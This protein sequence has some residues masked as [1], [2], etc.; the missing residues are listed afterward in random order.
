MVLVKKFIHQRGARM[1]SKNLLPFKFETTKHSTGITGL[2]GLPVYYELARVAGLSKSIEKHLSRLNT[3]QG[4]EVNRIVE[5]LLL[6]NLAGGD[7]VEDIGKLEGDEGLR[8]LFK[9]TEFYGRSRK[10]RHKAMRRFRKNKERAFPSQSTIFRFL[11]KFHDSDQEQLREL[12]KAFIPKLTEGLKKLALINRDQL[13]YLQD[14]QPE[15]IATLD[16][17]ATLV[18]TCKKDALHCYKHFKAYQPLNTYWYEQRVIVHTE[19]RDGNVPAGYNQLRVFREALEHLP[20]GVEK[21]YLRSDTAGYQHDLLKYCDSNSDKKYGKILFAIGCDVTASF[22]Q[23][24][25]EVP[26]KDWHPIYKDVNGKRFESGQ[27]WAEVCFVPNKICSSKK[28]MN[29]RYI[30]MREVM[31]QPELPGMESQQEFPFP[32][33]TINRKR[34]KVFGLVTNIHNW[35]GEEVIKW[36]RQRC[37]KS[38]HVH[39]VM[40]KD[41]AGGQLPCNE[42]GANAAWWW[43]MMISLNLN[44]IMKTLTLEPSWRSKRMKAIRYWLINVP[45]RLIKRSRQLYLRLSPDHPGSDLITQM[46]NRIIQLESVAPG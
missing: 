9:Q 3:S 35:D 37:G 19:F 38:E 1:I 15:K 7:C 4:W 25:L 41:L 6:L 34:Y 23:S 27:E 5:S 39:S 16:M 26:N 21:V 46:R 42:F 14:H 2:S 43:I 13:Q 22:K 33:Q 20:S 11:N 17:D 12:G 29:Y 18:E 45:G 40:K 44:E 24:V 31:G 10:E 30:A 36:Q 32:T 8:E 28:G